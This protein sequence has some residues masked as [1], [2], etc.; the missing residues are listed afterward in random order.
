MGVRPLEVHIV[1]FRQISFSST[2]RF[3]VNW[4]LSHPWS[5]HILSNLKKEQTEINSIKG[6]VLEVSNNK[7]FLVFNFVFL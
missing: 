4:S 1:A 7:V 5:R 6:F 2:E 3:F